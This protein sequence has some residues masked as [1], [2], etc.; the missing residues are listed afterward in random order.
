MLVSRLKRPENAWDGILVASEREPKLGV[1]REQL[2][3][4]GCNICF[5][6]RYR[7][8]SV[9]AKVTG[10]DLFHQLVQQSDSNFLALKRGP[11]GEHSKES[12]VAFYFSAFQQ[13]EVSC[14][15]LGA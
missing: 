9:E 11:D 10:R 8:S 2:G 4:L 5:E 13:I 1:K 14:V 12:Y 15:S 7:A 6:R 3:V